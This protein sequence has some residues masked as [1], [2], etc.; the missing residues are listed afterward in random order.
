MRSLRAAL[1]VATLASSALTGVVVS[2]GAA[3]AD[4]YRAKAVTEQATPTIAVNK[5]AFK[6]A[7]PTVPFT[8]T[9]TSTGIPADATLTVTRTT[10]ESQDKV[11]AT[12]VPD[13]A[14][15]FRFTDV[16]NMEGMAVYTVSYPGTGNG[17]S[18]QGMLWM[19]AERLVTKLTLSGDGAV[20]AY[21]STVTFTAQLDKWHTNRVVE[22][23]ADP[24]GSDQPH[25][26]IKK[27][28]VD[29][30]GKLSVKMR[31]TRNTTLNAFYNGDAK[32]AASADWIDVYTR[33]AVQ[34][35]IT[36]HFKTKKIG[37]K[38]YFVVRTTKD[39]RFTTTMTA[40][41]DRY[42][43][44]VVQKYSGGKWKSFATTLLPLDAKG[45][46]VSSFT[47][48]YPAGAKFRVR[49]EYG[50]TRYSDKLNLKT[51]GSWQY[52]TYAK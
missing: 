31:M 43:R 13:G 36:K 4:T 6:S 40:Y 22:I 28:A 3:A 15:A 29:S 27:G 33:V 18:A 1:V 38:K 46:S 17:D 10:D 19:R 42:Y 51:Y 49:A 50:V 52:Y 32:Y 7:Q 30:A 14:G 37:S 20:H 44:L 26:L 48:Y 16:L 11:I 47:G 8:L 39:P 24:A 5:P 45:K 21:G 2:A 34:T 35:K 41:P 9:G 25:R 12:V 23:W